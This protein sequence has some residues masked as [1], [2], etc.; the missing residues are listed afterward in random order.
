MEKNRLVRF[1]GK[2]YVGGVCHGIGEYTGTNP[3]LWR[4]IMI[5]GCFW[6]M[7]AILW[8]FLKTSERQFNLER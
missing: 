2:G 7:Y 3:I 5:F 8:I 6:G 1:P 4:L